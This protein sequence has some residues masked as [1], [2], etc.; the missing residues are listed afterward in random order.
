VAGEVRYTDGS[1]HIKGLTARHGSTPIGLKSAVVQPRADGHF[2]VWLTGI[3]AQ[4]L[5]ADRELLAALPEGLRRGLEAVQLAP[6]FNLAASVTLDVVVPAGVPNVRAWWNGGISFRKAA[7]KAGTNITDASGQFYCSGHFDGQKLHHVEGQLGLIEAKVLGQPL[8]N[9]TARLEVQPRSPDTIRFRDLKASL[10][11]G[12]LGGQAAVVTA[13]TLR[14]SL[15]L[16]AVNV[17]LEQ[18]GRHNLGPTAKAEDFVGPVRAYVRLNGEGDDLRDLRGSGHVD[19]ADGKMGQLPLILDMFKALGLTKP[20]GTAFEQLHM[21][22]GIDGPRLNV[23]VLDL[24]GRAISLRGGGGMGLD[25]D[26][27]KLDFTAMPG[28]IGWLPP[29]LDRIPG[30][31]SRQ[32]LKISMRGKLGK[33]GQVRFDKELVPAVLGPLRGAIGK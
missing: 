7:L 21:E 11:G 20:D 10:F 33:G 13:P 24:K 5:Q 29:P 25:G 22:F 12:T 28:L 30:I 8:T 31:F 19:V 2:N 17:R 18:F 9:V 1:I 3:S 23:H 4:G 16:D 14:Y 26:D 6:A 32:L 15:E 27:V